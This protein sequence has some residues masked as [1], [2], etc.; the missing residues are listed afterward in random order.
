VQENA[1]RP[2][3]AVDFPLH[4]LHHQ[5]Q[6]LLVLHDLSFLIKLLDVHGRVK[7][8]R[9]YPLDLCLCFWER[10]IKE[11]KKG[12]GCDINSTNSLGSRLFLFG[13]LEK[14]GSSSWWLLRM[15]G[16]KRYHGDTFVDVVQYFIRCHGIR[17]NEI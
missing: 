14:K 11:Q 3:A 10:K 17:Q 16:K 4:S 13:S 1:S 2:D 8:G 9:V 15:S 6:L 12:L 5:S 7:G